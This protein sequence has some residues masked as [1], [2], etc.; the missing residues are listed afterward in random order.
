L[1]LQ[2]NRGYYY[3]KEN[4]N[5]NISINNHKKKGLIGGSFISIG[6]GLLYGNLEDDCNNCSSTEDFIDYNDK[7]IGRQKIGYILIFIGGIMI[8]L[9]I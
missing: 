8:S 4:Q 2:C 7:L 5:S 3:Y 1:E 6:V 9:G